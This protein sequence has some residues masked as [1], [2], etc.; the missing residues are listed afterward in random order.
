MEPAAVAFFEVMSELSDEAAGLAAERA[1]DRHGTGAAAPRVYAMEPATG[2]WGRPPD[3]CAM[4]VPAVVCCSCEE[5]AQWTGAPRRK[6]GW[7]F[8][9]VRC[10]CGV[11]VV[12]SPVRMMMAGTY[13]WWVR[14]WSSM[15]Q[16]RW[17]PGWGP[18]P[19][20][21]EKERKKW[22]ERV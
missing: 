4:A 17:P 13:H 9:G 11:G 18:E 12:R 16:M 21:W 14:C 7:W 20:T 19:P 10:S 2:K 22:T 1:G 5:V 3:L 6:A 8:Y 15:V